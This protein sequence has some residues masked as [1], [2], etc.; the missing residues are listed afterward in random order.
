[1][2]EGNRNFVDQVYVTDDVSSDNGQII[3]IGA[4]AENV[5]FNDNITLPNKLEEYQKQLIAETD[6]G[7]KITS[8][9]QI[10]INLD[11]LQLLKI[12]QLTNVETVVE[13]ILP[14]YEENTLYYGACQ[15]L[16]NNDNSPIIKL[17]TIRTKSFFMFI[18]NTERFIIFSSGRIWRST[19]RKGF[20]EQEVFTLIQNSI[21]NVS[22]F[23]YFN[24]LNEFLQLTKNDKKT[25]SYISIKNEKNIEDGEYLSLPIG[26]TTKILIND[27]GAMYI[28]HYISN[29]W[30]EPKKIDLNAGI[31]ALETQHK[32]D[33]QAL[34][35]KANSIVDQANTDRQNFN[36]S[37]DEIN[38]TLDTK[39]NVSNKVSEITFPSLNY[40]PDTKAVFDYVN[41]KLE[42]PLAAID[43]CVTDLGKVANISDNLY[44]FN[45]YGL[46]AESGADPDNATEYY[47]HSMP[48]PVKIGDVLR[49]SKHASWL[50][51]FITM[52]DSNNNLVSLAKGSLTNYYTNR[53]N[54]A[55]DEITIKTFTYNG[56][57]Y[58]GKDFEGYIIISFSQG[59]LVKDPTKNVIVKNIAFPDNYAEYGKVTLNESIPLTAQQKKELLP[60]E[61]K[62]MGVKSTFTKPF[63]CINFD[64]FSFD[65]DRFKIVHDEYGFPA[66]VSIIPNFNTTQKDYTNYIKLLESNWDV[67]LYQSAE[68]PPDTYGDEAYSDSPTQEVVSAWESYVSKTVEKAK[69]YGIYLPITWLC[70]Q[71]RTC[72]AL[73]EACKKHGIKYIRGDDMNN[74]TTSLYF[75]PSF[76]MAVKPSQLYPDTVDTVLENINTAVENGYGC[77][78]FSHRLYGDENTAKKNYGC[79]VANLRK[80]LD[81]IKDLYDSGK[82]EVITFSDMYRKYFPDEMDNIEKRRNV[83]VALE[84]KVN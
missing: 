12:K 69:M 38:T 60:I 55:Y 46:Y 1:M 33:V 14:Y 11:N 21:D 23:S 34:T 13:D 59:D 42:T 51:A 84:S 18:E 47:W 65:D 19:V 4:K 6:S 81:K 79:T 56:I 36:N 28:S 39:E 45:D 71:M 80:V 64:D 5:Y 15:G 26:E 10:S 16:I 58:I 54:D 3:D 74:W 77:T 48:I 68:W 83:L 53:D 31:S 78:V 82:I 72:V 67:G 25:F 41:S 61:N 52:Y 22:S 20:P 37:I 29:L 70:R 49:T 35:D 63:V 62:V 40:Y 57:T 8:D 17:E 43:K 32:T 2:A 7:I 73:E 9:N 24:N 30:E 27:S 50:A 44:Q 66:T 75:K 76:K